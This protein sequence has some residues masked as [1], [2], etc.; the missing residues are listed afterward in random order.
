MLYDQYDHAGA[1]GDGL[2][3]LR[4][5][6]RPLRRRSWPTTSTSPPGLGWNV[7]GSRCRGRTSTAR[8]RDLGQRRC[9]L[10]LGRP[11]RHT[12]GARGRTRA[13][14]ATRTSCVTLDPSIGLFEGR[15]WISVQANQ[16]FTSAGQWAWLDRTEQATS[17]GG[18]AEPGRRPGHDLLG[19][20]VHATT[21]IG[22]GAA[23]DQVFRLTGSLGAPPPAATSASATSAACRPP[24]PTTATTSAT[25]ATTATASATSGPLSDAEGARDAPRSREAE[26]PAG[27]LLCREGPTRAR[28]AIA[29]GPRRQ[30]R[31]RGR[32]RSSAG[33]TR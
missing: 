22:D 15:Y 9:L 7:T 19:L 8:A 14:R 27:A 17:R 23:P 20:G 12:A 1:I 11:A 31:R 32:E 5:R 2:P 6:A 4:G 30:A 13:S 21:C 33:A 24:P 3:E 25:T 29:M 10:R 16:T 28:R 26:D 18:L